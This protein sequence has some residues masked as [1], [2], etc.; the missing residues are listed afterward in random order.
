MVG[1]SFTACIR[2]RS[3]HR[4]AARRDGCGVSPQPALKDR[5]TFIRRSAAEELQ[6]LLVPQQYPTKPR[7]PFLEE[8]G[9]PLGKILTVC[10]S[11]QGDEFM[12]QVLR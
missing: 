9:E 7:R 3:I 4:V 2:S 6:K 11:R 8:S 12:L 5:P 1:R 10:R